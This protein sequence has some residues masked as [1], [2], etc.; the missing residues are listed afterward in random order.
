M[1]NIFN[2]IKNAY[3]RHY[4]PETVTVRIPSNWGDDYSE[5]TYIANNDVQ[6][7]LAQYMAEN[8]SEICKKGTS[9]TD[10]DNLLAKEKEWG[11]KRHN[12]KDAQGNVIPAMH[13]V[14]Y[15]FGKTDHYELWTRGRRDFLSGIHEWH[16]VNGRVKPVE[17][18][19]CYYMEDG[20]RKETAIANLKNYFP[21][22]AA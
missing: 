4:H 17:G 16:V 19:S 8:G 15:L 2:A 11:L 1:L 9:I 18:T 20:L 3:N 21:M 14:S 22:P 10:S 13:R 7:H 6:K 12:G 5:I